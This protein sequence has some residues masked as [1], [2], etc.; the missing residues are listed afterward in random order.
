[1]AVNKGEGAQSAGASPVERAPRDNGRGGKLKTGGIKEHLEAAGMGSN[2]PGPTPAIMRMKFRRI[3][4]KR[5]TEVDDMME[6]VRKVVFARGVKAPLKLK[7]LREYFKGLDTI[8]KYSGTAS[9]SLTDSDGGDLKLPPI[10][11]NTTE[12]IDP[13]RTPDLCDTDIAP[14][15]WWCSRKKGHDGPCAARLEKPAA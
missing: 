9:V 2:G 11:L 7:A 10:Q 1:M 4:D 15:G 6:Q 8:A 5:I 14:P 12:E 13:P 3:L